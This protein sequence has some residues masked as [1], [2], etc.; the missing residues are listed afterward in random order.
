MV[1]NDEFNKDI[2]FVSHK[3]EESDKEAGINQ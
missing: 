1:E 2:L 3:N